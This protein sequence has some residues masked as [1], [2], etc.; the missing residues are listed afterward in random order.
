M[1]NGG[2]GKEDLRHSR[3]GGRGRRKAKGTDA[4]EKA[5]SLV[6]AFYKQA[7][8]GFAIQC[9]PSPPAL[10]AC[11]LNPEQPAKRHDPG[12]GHDVFQPSFSL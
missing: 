10:P 11:T 1:D 8:W 9:P 2:L 12:E 7:I 4:A 5:R 6:A 3:V